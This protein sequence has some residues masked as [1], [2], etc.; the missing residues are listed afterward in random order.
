MSKALFE[1]MEMSAFNAA[2]DRLEGRVS[3]ARFYD[4]KIQQLYLKYPAL[5]RGLQD[6]EATGRRYAENYL[7]NL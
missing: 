3:D 5:E 1:K 7:K 2:L 4:Q 6:A